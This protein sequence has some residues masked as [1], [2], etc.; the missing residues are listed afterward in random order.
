[1]VHAR[2][3]APAADYGYD[4]SFAYDDVVPAERIGPP[5][6]SR[7][8]RIARGGLA[9]LTILGGG[10]FL[11][12]HQEEVP[13]WT[14]AVIEAVSQLTAAPSEPAAAAP[15]PLAERRLAPPPFVPV[16]PRAMPPVEEHPPMA[17]VV[18][19]ADAPPSA[20]EAP[21]PTVTT[22]SLPPSVAKETPEAL[23]QVKAD[24]SDPLQ[25][26]AEA[27]G[28]HPGLSRVL[29]KSLTAADFRNAGHAVQT[30]LAQ[31]PDSAVFVWPRQQERGHAVFKVRFVA[32]ADAGCR[33]YV[34]TVIKDRWATTA[35]PMEKCGVPQ[36]G[37]S[38]LT[39][40][41]PRQ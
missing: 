37:Q 28:L 1:M 13:R 5:L 2:Y 40:H 24:P 21:A 3:P 25:V 11:L 33:R 14:S 38:R 34:V 7:S 23:E 41:R 35:R 4:P 8:G 20:A 6:P 39:S 26:R 17:P 31:T 29:L 10:W 15:P 18:A 16:A 30:A 36:P 19:P 12:Q 22:A 9:L 32:G 27:A